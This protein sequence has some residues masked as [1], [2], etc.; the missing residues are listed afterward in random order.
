MVATYGHEGSDL[1]AVLDQ[2]DANAFPNGR[3]WL[4]G[5]NSDLL[6]NNALSMGRPSCW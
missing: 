3:V 5:L 4:L 6:Q 1:F 2:L